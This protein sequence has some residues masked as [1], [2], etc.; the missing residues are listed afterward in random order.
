[1]DG[2]VVVTGPVTIESGATLNSPTGDLTVRAASITVKSGGSITAAPTGQT[3]GGTGVVTG[4]DGDYSCGGVGGSYGTA[5][6]VS[7]NT[8]NC[9]VP[10]PPAAAQGSST[11]VTV[12]PGSPGG[13][14]N[15]WYGGTAGTGGLGGGRIQLIAGT[16]NIAGQVTANGANGNAGTGN[17]GGGGGGGSGGGI[18]VAADSLTLTGTISTSGG[19]G[20]TGG[21]NNA[22]CSPGGAGGLGRVK[23][24]YGS[25]NAVSGTV[26]GAK[27]L[28]LLPPLTITSSTHPNPALI[29]N[30]AFTTIA[31]TWNRSFPSVQGYYYDVNQTQY[32]PATA[33]TGLFVATELVAISRS[34]VSAGSNWFHLVPIDQ[35]ST[36]GL[37]ENQFGIQ[38]N[39]TPP[40]VSSTSHPSQ[41]TWTSNANVLYAWTLPT[42]DVNN[43]GVYYVLDHYGTTVPTT[44]ATFLP[45]T[46]KQI[47]LTNL[48]SGIWGF[49]T[50]ALDQAGYLTTLG[51]HYRVLIGTNPGVGGL[52][53]NVTDNHGANVTGAVVTINKGLLSN[54]PAIVPDQVTNA[55]AYNFNSTVPVG[56][57]EIQVSASGFQTQTQNA[58]ITAGNSTTLDFTLM[59]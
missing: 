7:P 4:S 10:T 53:G 38:V 18:L 52:L 43:K 3:P 24:L 29:Y 36:V 44:A 26:T 48:A 31:L 1:M 58:V 13:V 37:I 20:G 17:G 55:G 56:T 46:Q 12:S 42:A 54:A 19:T 27:T 57:W 2:V 34:A 23:L 45:V 5:G 49:H 32:A 40:T 39:T 8:Y 28:G 47:L 50:V 16:I 9:Q 22:Q 41:T 35:T 33:A 59:P 21:N 6:S 11:D 15:N 30:D 51:G 25:L 14:G